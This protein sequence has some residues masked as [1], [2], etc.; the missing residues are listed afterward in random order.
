M[1][2]ALLPLAL[3]AAC[4]GTPRVPTQ[5]NVASVERIA[6]GAMELCFIAK[7]RVQNANDAPVEFSGGF[8]E[9]QLRG[10]TIGSGV[11]EAR[12]SVPRFGGVAVDVPVTVSALGQVRQA[13]GL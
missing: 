3:L 7:L 9:L 13:L 12:G 4:A 2:L 1:T 8:V 10:K 6:G 5:V 11:S